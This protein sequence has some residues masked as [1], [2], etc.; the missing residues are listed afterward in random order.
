VLGVLR[1]RNLGSKPVFPDEADSVHLKS[2]PE[3]FKALTTRSSQRRAGPKSIDEAVWT[4][5]ASHAA[6]LR[7]TRW[8]D[9]DVKSWNRV[10]AA[11]GKG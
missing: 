8:G 3:F 7:P 5:K 4:A 11:R 6:L 10:R 9:G 2:G 1:G